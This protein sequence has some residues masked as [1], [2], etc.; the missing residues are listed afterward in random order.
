MKKLTTLMVIAVVL[1]FALIMTQTVPEKEKHKEAMMKAVKEYIDEEATNRGFGDNVLTNLGKNV[2]VKTVETALNSKLKV[3]N[4]YVL[5]TTYVRLNGEEQM[6]S[7]G[8]LGMVFTFDKEMLREKL[9]EALNAKEEAIS[10]KEAA[11][12]SAR[13]LKQAEKEQK[14]RE[15]ELAKEQ[16]KREKELKKEQKRREKEA[17]K[18]QKRLEKESKE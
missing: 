15:K 12:Q 17:R 8:M 11:K 10:E 18:E 14:K 6:L 5:N 13:E 1:M 4:Y 9:Q 7:L 2:V 16:K 3:H